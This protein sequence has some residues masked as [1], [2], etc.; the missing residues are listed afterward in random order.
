VSFTLASFHVV[1]PDWEKP[2]AASILAAHGS[3][4]GNATYSMATS[5][6]G[7]ITGRSPGWGLLAGVVIEQVAE[8]GAGLGEEAAPGADEVEFF[9]LGGAD[10]PVA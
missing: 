10:A 4:S 6:A 2:A 9:P 5:T 8:V 7:L 3:A 1:L